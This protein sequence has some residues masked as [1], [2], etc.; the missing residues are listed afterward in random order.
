MIFACI[1]CGGIIE[2][3]LIVVGL[4]VIYRWFKSRHKKDKCPCCKERKNE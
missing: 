3:W 4:G 1:A 2:T